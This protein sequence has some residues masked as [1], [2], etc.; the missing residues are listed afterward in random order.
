MTAVDPIVDALVSSVPDVREKLRTARGKTAT[1]NPSGDVQSAADREID[2]L[3]RERVSALEAVGA[4]ASEEREAVEDVG[5][6]FSVAI[7]PLDG[8]SNLRSNNIVG[9][10][11]GIYDGP[12]PA[13]G[14]DLVASMVLL[15]GP[16][17]TI[18]VAVDGTVT[19][20]VVD[21]GRIVDSSPVAIPD[22]GDICGFAGS[23]NEW[24]EAVRDCWSEFHR[25]HKLRYTGAMVADINHLLVD[26]GVVGYPERTTS[27]SGDLRLQY[28]ANPI[29][30]IVEAAGG[31]SSTGQKSILDRTP[32]TLHEHTPAYFGNAERIGLLESTLS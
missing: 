20:H 31:Q 24:P 4:Y 17:T 26:G 15:Y 16:Y 11:V 28:E 3:F 23:T 12:L 19:R 7:D 10:V 22:E 1:E 30:Y 32:E 29:A 18:T 2:R 6:G 13:S 5:D 25:K 8:S 27:P 14:R 9:T 21:D